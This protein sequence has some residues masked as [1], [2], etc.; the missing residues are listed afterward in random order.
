[1][2]GKMFSRGFLNRKDIYLHKKDQSESRYP[3][4]DDQWAC[5]DTRCEVLAQTIRYQPYLD[6]VCAAGMGMG[7][8]LQHTDD[9]DRI[10]SHILNLISITWLK[11]AVL[12]M[13]AP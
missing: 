12:E 5:R 13:L 9:D 11:R 6:I 1:M 10:L 2:V 4:G 7:W 8:D 3:D